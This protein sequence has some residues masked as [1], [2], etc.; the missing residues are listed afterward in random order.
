MRYKIVDKQGAFGGFYACT[1]A[2][3]KTA[4]VPRSH[5]KVMRT[6]SAKGKICNTQNRLLWRRTKKRVVL[7]LAAAPMTTARGVGAHLAH[8]VVA[9][10]ASGQSN[11]PFPKALAN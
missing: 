6:L 1:D 3:I 7:R 9:R 4:W 10:L 5:I 8:P 2:G 11:F